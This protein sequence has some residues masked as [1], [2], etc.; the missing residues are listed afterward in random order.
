MNE[1]SGFAKN[2]NSRD[3]LNVQNCANSTENCIYQLYGLSGFAE[4]LNI[5]NFVN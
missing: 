4:N 3:M 1:V 2:L 5:Q